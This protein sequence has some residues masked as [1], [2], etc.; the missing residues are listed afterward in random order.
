QSAL[1]TDL[2]SPPDQ[3]RLVWRTIPSYAQ[4]APPVGAI[5]AQLFEPEL[6]A[7][8]IVPP[9]GALRV[10]LLRLSTAAGRSFADAMFSTLRFNGKTALENGADFREFTVGDPSRVESKPGRDGGRVETDF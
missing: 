9:R 8:G 4:S 7:A 3:P 5:V 6:R 1:I 10:A 2:V